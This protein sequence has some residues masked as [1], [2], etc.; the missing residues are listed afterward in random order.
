LHWFIC[1][2]TI[3]GHTNAIKRKAVV[4]GLFIIYIELTQTQ[5]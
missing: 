5:H 2:L 4:I 1:G 3:K